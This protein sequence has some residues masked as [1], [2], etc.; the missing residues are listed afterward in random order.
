MSIRVAVIDDQALVRGG[1]TMVLNHQSDID[2]VAEAGT[3]LAAIDVAREHRPD[4]VLMDIR[5][6]EMDGLEATTRI[7]EEADW[8]VRV[9]IV[10]TFDPD[11]YIY[12]A[13]R[14]GASGFVLKDT[15]PEDL[16]AAVRIVAEGGALLSPSITRRLIGRFADQLATDTTLAE[17]LNELTEREREVF[18]G[19]ARG[20][21]NQE[22]SD[23]L[24]IGAAT[25]KTHVSNILSKLGVR[26][27]AQAVVFA[28]E[29]GLI[30]AGEPSNL[31]R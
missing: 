26:D 31:H 28:Y 19:L 21:N 3:G 9:L 6:P 13:L 14:A 12:K 25:V 5:M 2:V 16:V 30:E 23:T 17:K 20:L 11:E 15:R 4:V 29:S 10:T 27:R 24:F 1:F 22:I 7:V 8:P 18:L